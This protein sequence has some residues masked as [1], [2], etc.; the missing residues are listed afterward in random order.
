[1]EA[2]KLLERRINV[3]TLKEVKEFPKTYNALITN[4]D[5][6]REGDRDALYLRLIIKYDGCMTNVLVC[7]GSWERDLDYEDPWVCY[8]TK[9]TDYGRLAAA[10]MILC[11]II[12]VNS[13]TDFAKKYIRVKT[14]GTSGAE[15]IVAIGNIMADKWVELAKLYP[16]GGAPEIKALYSSTSITPSEEPYKSHYWEW[17]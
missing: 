9:Y 11:D 1:M 13:L 6:Y 8:D 2:G 10:I 15:T 17:D 16:D 3:T 7:G 12:E 14:I 4:A 5:I